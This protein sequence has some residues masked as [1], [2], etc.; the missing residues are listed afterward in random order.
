MGISW[1]CKFLEPSSY[2]LSQC[3]EGWAQECMFSRDPQRNL[4]HPGVGEALLWV[5]CELSALS[6]SHDIRP[7][8]TQACGH[9]GAPFSPGAASSSQFQGFPSRSAIFQQQPENCS[10][11]PNV[12]LTCLGIQQP[13][14][15]QQVTIQVQEP[16]DMLSSMPGATAASA[17]RGVSISPNTSQVQMQLRTSLMAALSYGHRPLS[18]QLSADSAEA[19]R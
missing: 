14:Q 11:P 12:A 13:P 17:G 2:L 5:V 8:V 10:P 15:P 16:V 7:Q 4:P 6:G 3:S 18:K 19:H 9:S 1:N